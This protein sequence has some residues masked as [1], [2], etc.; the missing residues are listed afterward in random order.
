MSRCP[1]HT[2][3]QPSRSINSLR[4]M[5]YRGI[6]RTARLQAADFLILTGGMAVRK[7]LGE[8]KDRRSGEMPRVLWTRY[9]PDL[10]IHRM[11]KHRPGLG[12][13]LLWKMVGR[14]ERFAAKSSNQD[15]RYRI[16][17]IQD[18]HAFT[19]EVRGTHRIRKKGM[20]FRQ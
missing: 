20:P 7:E 12:E 6:A 9:D 3:L 2:N 16:R 13:S 18:N 11:L 10:R 8:Q 19:T 4:T 14:N 17:K 5:Y 1:V 15:G